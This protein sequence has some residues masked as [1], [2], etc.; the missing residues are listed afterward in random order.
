MNIIP[1]LTFLK[2][3]DKTVGII[4]ILCWTVI[5]ILRMILKHIREQ[6]REKNIHN[7]VIHLSDNNKKMIKAFY[8]QQSNIPP[9]SDNGKVV[10]FDDYKKKVEKSVFEEK[11]YT[12]HR[13]FSSVRDNRTKRIFCSVINKKR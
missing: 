7:E 9:P 2:D 12:E 1:D 6:T 11:E 3:L 8:F 4:L 10:F 5:K 13:K